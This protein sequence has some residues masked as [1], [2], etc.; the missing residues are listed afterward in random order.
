MFW[1]IR[2]VM[3]SDVTSS[4]CRPL[5]IC[6]CDDRDPNGEVS[7]NQKSKVGNSNA[8]A[9]FPLISRNDKSQTVEA[10]LEISGIT[11]AAQESG[12]VVFRA[13]LLTYPTRW[14]KM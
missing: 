7:E 1:E 2:I 3:A 10:S 5:G 9:L 14:F 11:A 8:S 6:D 4:P 13:R 12:S